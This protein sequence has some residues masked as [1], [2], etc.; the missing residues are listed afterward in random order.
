M[1]KLGILLVFFA[2]L[3]FHNSCVID[4]GDL[5]GDVVFYNSDSEYVID[6]AVDGVNVGSITDFQDTNP[7]CNGA[8]GL[9]T[10]LATG[11]YSNWTAV[12]R[13]T[14]YTWSGA[15]DGSFSVLTAGCTGVYLEK[16]YGQIVF[17]Q[18]TGD[19]VVEV[20]VNDVKVGDIT[21]NYE[22]DS[23]TCGSE[24]CVTVTLPVGTYSN[25]HAK[26]VGGGT[27]Q[28]NMDHSYSIEVTED[29][30]FAL[31]LT[32]KKGILESVGALNSE[33]KA[34]PKK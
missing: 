19:Y 30:C 2:V 6:V 9:V 24:G 22:T 11:T 34:T 16:S 14:G 33:A 31:Q 13:T 32:A 29:G 7:G 26:E 8:G 17:W 25:W 27:L 3:G 23:P 18:S 28:W 12:E 10:S 21:H 4:L 5:E 1:K 20:Y 15:T